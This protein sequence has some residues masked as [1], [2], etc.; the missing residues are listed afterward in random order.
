FLC[1]LMKMNGIILSGGLFSG[2]TMT[3]FRHNGV[4]KAAPEAFRKLIKLVI[5]VDFDG[6]LGGVHHDVAFVA[7]MEMLIQLDFEVLADLA[8]KIIGQLL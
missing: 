8:V 4:M 7:P 6:F 2:L 1:I 5:A 3:A